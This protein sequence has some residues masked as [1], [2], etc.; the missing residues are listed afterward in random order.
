MYVFVTAVMV[1]EQKP[2]LEVGINGAWLI[3]ALATQSVLILGRLLAPEMSAGREVDPA[4]AHPRRAASSSRTSR[5]RPDRLKS[6]RR[7]NRQ[8][9]VT[10]TDRRPVRPR[11]LAVLLQELV[12]EGVNEMNVG[13]DRR[14]EVVGVVGAKPVFPHQLPGELRNSP[15]QVNQD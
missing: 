1:R 7:L 3:A 14:R 4:A 11:E 12:V 6:Q 2:S 10:N 15:V 13:I 5:L 8:I 9:R